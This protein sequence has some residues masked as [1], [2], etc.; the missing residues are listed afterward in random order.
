MLRSIGAV[1][2]GLAVG[3][4]VNMAIVQLNMTLLHPAPEG[5]DTNDM[6]QL[7]AYMDTLPAS[8]FLVVMIAHLGQSFVGGWV[9]ARL[10]AS[11]VMVMAMTVGVLSMA[12]GIAMM[13]MI[14]GPTWMYIELPLYLV[15]A[16]FAG[17][18][19]Q[20]KQKPTAPTA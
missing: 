5:L 3:M 13:F 1:I 2:A 16:W 20:K 9:A 4:V 6:D 15:V 18:L 17:R 19:V 8:A 14:S 12:G 10:A 7:Q 11:N